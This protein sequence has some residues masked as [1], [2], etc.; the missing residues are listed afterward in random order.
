MAQAPVRPDWVGTRDETAQA[1]A[2]WAR[3]RGLAF[4]PT[5]LLPPASARLG[6]GF[7]QTDQWAKVQGGKGGKGFGSEETRPA[8]FSENVCSGPLPGGLIGVLA[9]HSYLEY[10]SHGETG[11]WGAFGFTAVVAEVPESLRVTRAL[12]GDHPRDKSKLTAAIEGKAPYGPLSQEADLTPSLRERYVWELLIREDPV[13]VAEAFTPELIDALASAPEETKI[14]VQGGWVVAELW[15]YRWETAELDGLCRTASAVA[16]AMRTAAAALP[17]IEPGAAL[18]G[19]PPNQIERWLDQMV[20]QVEWPRPP[21]NVKEAAQA[22]A[23]HAS[24]S[25]YAE[26]RGRRQ[27]VAVF[28]PAFVVF[29]IPAAVIGFGSEG[30][31]VGAIATLATIALAA[32]LTFLF[33]RRVREGVAATHSHD[34]G[35]EAFAREYARS[36]RLALE[37]TQEFRRR[38]KSP[39]HGGPQFSMRGRLGGEVDGRI[40]LW[41]DSSDPESGS[42]IWNLAMVPAPAGATPSAPESGLHVWRVDD[43]LVVGEPTDDERRSV[44]ALDALGRRAVALASG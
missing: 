22:Y 16:D 42:R 8:R 2:S 26:R 32:G 5:G 3:E 34:W 23:D 37:D 33:G 35:L 28:V 41:R 1:M 40:V 31:V 6:R 29:V 14:V 7:G 24:E 19:P 39:L 17:G 18:P 15:H 13:A 27:A 43:W 9:H 25:P 10:R 30:T 4:E 38:F 20:A 12:L 36:R 21:D 44:A 11:S